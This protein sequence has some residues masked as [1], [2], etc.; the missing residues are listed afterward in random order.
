[1]NKI[2]YYFN[3]DKIKT[4]DLDSIYNLTNDILNKNKYFDTKT[5]K[6]IEEEYKN[7]MKKNDN[8]TNYNNLLSTNNVIES[9][10]DEIH[11]NPKEIRKKTLNS[12]TKYLMK[13]NDINIIE[14]LNDLPNTFPIVYQ[15]NTKNIILFSEI[16]QEFLSFYLTHFLNKLTSVRQENKNKK[17]FKTIHNMSYSQD[18]NKNT[19][20]NVFLN[21]IPDSKCYKKMKNIFNLDIDFAVNIEQK[22]SD[23]LKY[24]T[25]YLKSPFD[26]NKIDKI[27]N[28]IITN[29]N[30]K[31]KNLLFCKN[32]KSESLIKLIIQENMLDFISE[33][34]FFEGFNRNSYFYSSNQ[35]ELISKYENK[36]ITKRL[37]DTVNLYMY[38]HT[39]SASEFNIISNEYYHTIRKEISIAMIDY[40]K[41]TFLY[42]QIMSYQNDLNKTQ[43]F[44]LYKDNII[45]N[46]SKINNKS[47]EKLL[48]LEIEKSKNLDGIIPI[49]NDFYNKIKDPLLLIHFNEEDSFLFKYSGYHKFQNDNKV[50]EKIKK[51]EQNYFVQPPSFT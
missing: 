19:A 42:Y 25:D 20:N 33:N 45:R 10:T 4:H 32:K 13:K 12:Y 41:D 47:E 7:I 1:M 15:L 2:L 29:I 26:K 37:Y 48:M 24:E 23:L 39:K 43:L 36:W 28:Q 11:Q 35:E 9:D 16:N 50:S 6:M 17:I 21:W 18:L 38:E 44:N 31:N 22:E 40:F 46:I 49:Y 8:K 5:L 34:V 3:E 30:N 51:V 14:L 27:Y